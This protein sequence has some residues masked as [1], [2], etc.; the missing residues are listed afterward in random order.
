MTNYN[1]QNTDLLIVGGGLCGLNLA[2]LAQ[3]QNLTCR[4][5]EGR[6]YS[7]GRILS[8]PY[9]SANT[10]NRYD[11]GPAWF[12]PHH[13]HIRQ[14]IE[15]LNL[16]QTVYEQYSEGAGLFENSNGQIQQTVHGMS[17][18]GSYR[19]A[20]GMQSLIDSIVMLLEPETV[21]NECVVQQ[22]ELQDGQVAVQAYDKGENTVFHSQHIVIALPPRV[23]MHGITF[24]P[25]LGESRED[26][27]QSFQTWMAAQ[28]KVIIEYA[29]PFWRNMGLSGDAFSLLGPI[30]ELHDA[31]SLDASHAALFGFLDESVLGVTLEES[32][33]KKDAVDQL[34]RLFGNEA[35]SFINI[36][37]AN[38]SASTFTC[39]SR[40]KIEAPMHSYNTVQPL[41]EPGW[42]EKLIWSGSETAEAQQ[43]INGY[44]EGAVVASKHSLSLVMKE[45]AAVK[46]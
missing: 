37:I 16:Q 34:T 6:T 22:V 8:R 4:V 38:W 29:R 14:L 18:A 35:N 17:M 25:P 31:S 30:R 15:E 7:G 3:E 13:Q 28:G 45:R 32:E 26:Y 44:L 5:L 9:Q 12:W 46:S 43:Q 11:L 36:D 24:L 10:E 42:R 1:K 19:L 23:A 21:L 41:I 40:D 20:G 33:I 27:L 39:T 2:R